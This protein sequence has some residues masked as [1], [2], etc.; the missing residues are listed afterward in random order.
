MPTDD[1]SFTDTSKLNSPNPPVLTQSTSSRS[2]RTHAANYTDSITPYIV[3]SDPSSNAPFVTLDDAITAATCDIGTRITTNIDEYDDESSSSR[4]R[5][6]KPRPHRQD[7]DLRLLPSTVLVATGNYK[8]TDSLD[9]KAPI[10][11]VSTAFGTAPNAL[12]TG[13]TV[14]RGNKSWEGVVFKCGSYELDAD[15]TSMDKFVNCTFKDDFYITVKGGTL[16]LQDC[17][18]MIE[19]LKDTWLLQTSDSS[20]VLQRCQVSVYGSYDDKASAILQLKGCSDRANIISDCRFDIKVNCRSETMSRT[21][22]VMQIASVQPLELTG[23]NMQFSSNHNKITVLGNWERFS[24]ARIV[25]TN[26]TFVNRTSSSLFVSL[27]GSI[28]SSSQANS[29]FGS[30]YVSR[31]TLRDLRLLSFD[32]GTCNHYPL[33]APGKSRLRCD[34]CN[35]DRTNWDQSITVTFC[36]IT[37]MTPSLDLNSAVISIQGVPNTTWILNLLNNNIS[38]NN[39]NVPIAI[40][41]ATQVYLNISGTTFSNV[42]ANTDIASVM[43]IDGVNGQVTIITNGSTTL[44]NL[45]QPQVTN[46]GAVI[47]Q[48]GSM[49]TTTQ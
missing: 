22:Y 36:D 9:T 20:I 15:K 10:N 29:P 31:S 2:N 39:R 42:T 26:N 37:M 25:A 44:S 34:H 24:G 23:T 45:A 46:S 7:S 8:L 6:Q 12:M 4:D 28:W 32:N 27:L 49:I 33:C 3:N 19:N 41:D 5:R 11:I 17:T 13:H 30:I 38:V 40:S 14:S 47:I 1:P 18:V 21:L 43:M 16:V 48:N 35:I